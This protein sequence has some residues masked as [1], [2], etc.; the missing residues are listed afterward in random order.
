MTA[1]Q[2]KFD[3]NH[4]MYQAVRPEDWK[5]DCI[6]FDDIVLDACDVYGTANCKNCP[7][8]VKK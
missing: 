7:N 8:Y 1:N 2:L 3:I 4:P 6:Y 5:L